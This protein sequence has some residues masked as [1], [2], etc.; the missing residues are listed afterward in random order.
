M[1]YTKADNQLH[2]GLSSED[3]SEIAEIPSHCCPNDMR[4]FII[5]AKDTDLCDLKGIA[6]SYDTIKTIAVNLLPPV[7]NPQKIICIG[8]NYKSHCDEQQLEYPKHP[9]FF[10]KFGNSLVGPTGNIK[11]DYN[12]H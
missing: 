11:G 3:G 6:Q 10:C 2:L 5:Q 1:Q 8:L 12:F 4:N 7:L 9:V